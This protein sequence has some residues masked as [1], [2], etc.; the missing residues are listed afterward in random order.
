MRAWLTTLCACGLLACAQDALRAVEGE[1]RV[2]PKQVDFGRVILG[3]SAEAALEVTNLSRG[4]LEVSITLSGRGFELV[5]PPA[6]LPVGNREVLVRFR[7]DVEGA[8]D[9]K[10]TVRPAGVAAIEVPLSGEGAPIPE[11]VASRPCH[12]SAWSVALGRCE[13]AVVADGAPCEA[14][15]LTDGMCSGG[16][17][18]GSPLDCQD[19]DACTVD[20]CHPERGCEHS[21]APACPGAGP[22][23]VGVCDPSSGCG[24]APAADGTPCGPRRD[25]DAAE[26]CIGGACALRDPPDDFICADESP[27]QGEGRC[28]A[29][30]CVRPPAIPLAPT[31]QRGESQPDGGPAEAWSDLLVEA[32]GGITL[33]SYFISQQLLGATSANPVSL[34]QGTARRC[35][36]WRGMLIC[37]DYPPSVAAGVSAVD[38]ATG[39]IVWTYSGISADLPEYAGPTVQVFLARLMALSE[40]HLAAL[41]ESRTLNP[42]GTDPR[43]RQFALVVLDGQGRKVAA[44]RVDHPSFFVCNHPHPYGA[45]VDVAGNVYLAFT[46]SG[47]DNP[48]TALE[49]TLL[50]SWTS[51]LV[52]RWARSNPALPGGE[53]AVAGGWLFHEHSA[54]SFSTSTGMIAGALAVPFAQ[55]VATRDLLIP[56]PGAFTTRLEA[57]DGASLSARWQRQTSGVPWYFGAPLALA[58]LSTGRGPRPVVLAFDFDGRAYSLAA[59][60]VETTAELFRCPLEQPE[61]PAVLSPVEGG[62]LVASDPRALAGSSTCERCDPRYARTRLTFRYFPMNGLLPGEGRWPVPNGGVG[63]DHREDPVP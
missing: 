55:G 58:R 23:Q 41:F 10:C 45:A 30:Q 12:T 53:L 43:C 5:D 39:T 40:Q 59:T 9:G 17:C 13:E 50:M 2:E 19:G 28:L 26:V 31:W 60:D 22:C 52:P 33:S 63:H 46:P 38:E 32:D 48:A 20:S 15:C 62:L 44:R 4:E 1:V 36:H 8:F 35:I 21:A 25:C 54:A 61:A 11:C 51:L 27:C 49:D 29:N 42:D 34:P 14:V 18:V 7:P 57:F 37:A 56:A 16:R 24:L 47:E 3:Q 6:R